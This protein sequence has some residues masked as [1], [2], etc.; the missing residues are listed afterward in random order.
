MGNAKKSFGP[1]SPVSVT[2]TSKKKLVLESRPTTVV[3]DDEWSE[4]LHLIRMS[5]LQKAAS[6]F[7]YCASPLTVVDDSSCKSGLVSK[8]SIVRRVC[9]KSS[10]FADPYCQEDLAVNTKSVV[11]ARAIGKERAGL[12]TFGELM[13]LSP[14]LQLL[15][16]QSTTRSWKLLARRRNVPFSLLLTSFV[17]MLMKIK[18]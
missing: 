11:T 6:A 12:E 3:S 2:T 5:G 15:P 16:F 18:L 4:D 13:G 17:R 7:S 9:G 10:P 1:S 8:L 14:P